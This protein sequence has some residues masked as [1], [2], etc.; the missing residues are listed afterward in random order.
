MLALSR[1]LVRRGHNVE[2]VALDPPSAEWLGGI[3]LPIHALGRGLTK[4]GYSPA[5][6]RWLKANGENYD[7]SPFNYKPG[8]AISS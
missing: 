2:V 5:L 3:D 8:D 4:Y 6:D 7:R 1:G